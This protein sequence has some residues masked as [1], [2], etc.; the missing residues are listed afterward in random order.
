MSFPMYGT[1]FAIFSLIN[2]KIIINRV[3]TKNGLEQM[4][5]SV[6]TCSYHSG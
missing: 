2:E 1:V 6:Q 3:M 4:H 5:E